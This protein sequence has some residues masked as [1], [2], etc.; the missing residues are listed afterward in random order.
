MF[1]AL[2]VALAKRNK[3]PSAPAKLA[4]GLL[5]VGSA[6]LFMVAAA[7]IV[8]KGGKVMPV[9]LI[10]TYVLHTVGELC[11][12]PIGMSSYTKLA[13]RKFVGQIMGVWF[14]SMSLG[15]LL[16]GLIAGLFDPNKIAAMPGQYLNL[17]WFAVIPGVILL[18]LVKPLKKWSGGIE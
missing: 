17:V 5:I 12:S 18:L 11:L 13:P 8:A 3:D 14:L 4:I 10:A 9:W 15:N 7:N 16:A 1:S 6:F 2:W